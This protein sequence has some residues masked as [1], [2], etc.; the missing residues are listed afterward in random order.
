MKDY[1][2]KNV[3]EKIKWF[4]ITTKRFVLEYLENTIFQA[5]L[6]FNV[7][8]RF[9]LLTFFLICRMGTIVVQ[10]ATVME[11]QQDNSCKT[12]SIVLKAV[13]YRL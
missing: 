6:A 12:L 3:L 9:P 5:I 1:Y 4:V 10:C 8:V 13:G 11:I 2:I 7:I